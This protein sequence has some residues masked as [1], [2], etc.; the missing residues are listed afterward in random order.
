MR[1]AG[2]GY[3]PDRRTV[4]VGLLVGD[5]LE[6]VEPGRPDGRDEA[7]DERRR[8]PTRSGSATMSAHGNGQLGEAVRQRLEHGRPEPAPTTMPEQRAED[9]DHHGLD[10]TIH[11]I[12]PR[13][14]P[15]ARSR[16]SSR[17]RSVIDSSSVLMMPSTAM[18]MARPSSS[19]TK[20]ST[21]SKIWAW[22]LP[23]KSSSWSAR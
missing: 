14:M 15:T 17:V 6:H 1:I 11:M 21:K 20:T 7:G 3:D 12:W 16:P 10:V 18:I 9:R 23:T 22:L 13:F 19:C 8:R 5:G 4:R 2:A